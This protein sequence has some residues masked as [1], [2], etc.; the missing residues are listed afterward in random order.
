MAAIAEGLWRPVCACPNAIPLVLT[1]RG[2]GLPTLAPAVAL[3]RALARGGRSGRDLLVAF[4]VVS[5]FAQAELAG[6][7]SAVRGAGLAA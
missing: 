4:R 7:L 6:P 1:R 5:R 3:L 2:V